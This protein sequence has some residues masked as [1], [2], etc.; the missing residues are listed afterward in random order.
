VSQYPDEKFS[1]LMGYDNLQEITM[2]KDCEKIL[3]HFPLVVYPREGGRTRPSKDA[4]AMPKYAEVVF[5][6]EPLLDHSSTKIRN[7]AR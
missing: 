7:F 5:L 6:D 4:P 3:K 1:L 2:W